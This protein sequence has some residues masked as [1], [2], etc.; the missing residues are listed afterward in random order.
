MYPARECC[1]RGVNHIVLGPTVADAVDAVVA[2][3]TFIGLG[4][5]VVRGVVCAVFYTERCFVSVTC[6]GLQARPESVV[7]PGT[8]SSDLYR[9]AIG[10]CVVVN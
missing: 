9:D 5:G 7:C 3:A 2:A 10:V 4:G 6:N 8:S 1:P